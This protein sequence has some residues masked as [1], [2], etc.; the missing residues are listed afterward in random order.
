MDTSDNFSYLLPF[1]FLVFGCICLAAGRWGGGSFARLWGLGFCAAA[2]GF[3]VPILAHA[4]PP[5]WQALCADA[6]FYL[7]FYAY[8]QALLVRFGLTSLRLPLAAFVV[9]AYG[10]LAYFVVVQGNL[11]GE[12]ATSDIGC[13]FLLGLPLL[14]VAGRITRPMD[15]LL[16]LIVLGVFLE[17]V[18]RVASL[19]IFTDG[20]DYASLDAFFNSEYAFY[21]QVAASVFGF[22]LALTVLAVVAVDVIEEHRHAAEHDPLTELL[23]RRG[24]ERALPVPDKAGF[25]AGTVVVCDI[26]HFKLVNDRFGHAA[27]DTVIVRLAA[28]L[29]DVYP[30]G[31]LVTRLGG[32]EFAAF[33]PQV[34]P[35]EAAEFAEAARSAFAATNWR[36]NGID[37]AITASFGVSATARSDH[38]VHDAVARADSCL[39]AAKTAGRNRVAVEGNLPT[40]SASPFIVISSSTG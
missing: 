9:L 35:S 34:K 18:V 5:M 26:D 30:Q 16:G 19:L 3:A 28:V 37:Q 17:T 11:R 13:A 32:E 10:L 4:L 15:K 21:T 29:R 25:A 24:F 36:E 14:T 22:L 20:S 27:G 1:I 33:L 40:P 8:G 39:Y 12:L 23:N 7:A 31:A 2:G 38:S 6:L